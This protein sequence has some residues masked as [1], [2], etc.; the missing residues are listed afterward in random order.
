MKVILGI[1]LFV[2]IIVAWA[3]LTAFPIKW[4]W[5]YL[6]PELF[7]LKQ[8]TFWQALGMALLCSFLFKSHHSSSED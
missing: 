4:L 3:L 8:I 2:A 1:I 7:S 5:N 6:M